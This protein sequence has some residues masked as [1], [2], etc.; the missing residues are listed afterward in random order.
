MTRKRWLRGVALG[1]AV[2][3]AAT[4]GAVGTAGA[5][6]PSQGGGKPKTGGSITYGLEAPTTNFCLPNAQLAISGIAVT[7]A[8]YD[9]LTVPDN[10]GK[11]VPYL[12]QSVNPSPDYMSWTIKLRPNIQFQNGEPL[13]ADAVKQNLDAYAGK[14][15]TV[16]A[17]LFAFVMSNVD[18]VTAVDPMTVQV[19]MK[20]PW[21]EFDQ[22]LWST[23]RLGIVA[24][25]QLN[26]PNCQTNMIGTGPFK[27]Q[28]FDPVTGNVDVVKNTNYWR[29]GFPYL[30]EIKFVPVPDG[31]QR[32]TQFQ[33]GALD[34][35]HDSVGRDLTQYQG[36]G[37]EAKITK[38]PNGR[39]EVT[40]TLP[41]LNRPPFDDPN[42]RK[43]IAEGIDRNKL[44]ELVNDGKARLANG[45]FDTKVEGYLSNAGYPKFNPKDAKK[46]A[47]QYKAA[48]GGTFEFSYQSTTD[49][50]GI[51]VARFLKSELAKIG[52]TVNLPQPVDQP[53]II[54]Q[55]IGGNVD[56]FGWRNY[57]GLVGDTMYVWF[58]GTVQPNSQGARNPV[59]F[60][61]FNNTQANQALDQ[62]RAEQDPAKRQQLYQDFNKALTSNISDFWGWYTPWFI[63]TKSNVHGVVGPNLPDT[64]GNPGSDK[65][66]PVLAGYHQMLGLWKG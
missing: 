27:L 56:T 25:A 48:H 44:N 61:F 66:T 11:Y 13:N 26:S 6:A 40:H 34:A 50:L 63:A 35:T 45:V 20:S 18:S 65:P 43:A 49:Q 22:Y 38:E 10:S 3:I 1:A 8:V 37:G 46:L 39:M 21:V 29:K 42:A 52:I 30:D 47:D 51:D 24:P 54:N 12:A 5:R 36:L 53:T 59:N 57:P 23:G 9:T 14:N 41:N 55:A 62:G 32:F 19:N 31:S 33:G 2:A 28:S 7:T 16:S 4:F 15:T 64:N 60:N 17:P 58:Y